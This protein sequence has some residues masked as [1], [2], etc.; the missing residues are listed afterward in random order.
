[1]P[2][3]PVLLRG[4]QDSSAKRSRLSHSRHCSAASRYHRP[5]GACAFF[6]TIGQIC[7]FACNAASWRPDFMSAFLPFF[8]QSLSAPNSDSCKA[9]VMPIEIRVFGR[10]ALAHIAQAIPEARD[11]RASQARPGVAR[12]RPLLASI[13]TAAS[14]WISWSASAA[15]AA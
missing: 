1:M 8:R 7:K 13:C 15:T 9:R 14:I 4:C 3:A 11:I 12:P 5:R 10:L 2:I 6:L